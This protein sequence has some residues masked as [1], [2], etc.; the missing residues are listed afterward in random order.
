MLPQP[1]IAY[2]RPGHFTGRKQPDIYAWVGTPILGSVL[3]HRLAKPRAD[4]VIYRR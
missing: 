2:M 4:L 1:R 3:G